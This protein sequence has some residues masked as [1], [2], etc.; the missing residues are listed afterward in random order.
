[1]GKR[2]ILIVL[3]SVGC[4]GAPDAAAYG[5]AGADTLGHLFEGIPG[6]RLPNLDSLG[7][8]GLM[9]REPSG[10]LRQG[11]S[12]FRL[13]EVSAGKDT[14][15]G[16][17]ELMGCLLEEPFY[18]C[19]SFPQGFVDTLAAACGTEFIGNKAASGTQILEE[20][21][22]EHLRTGFP[23]LYTSADSVLQIAAHEGTFGEGRLQDVCRTARRLLD[24]RGMRV[25]RVISRPFTGDETSGFR[26]TANRHDYSLTPGGTVLDDLVAKHVEVI[27]VGKISDIFAGK[28]ISVSHPTA[29]NAHG[30][31]LVG[32]LC[33]ERAD[34]EEFIFANLVDFDSLYGH[35][36]DPLGYARC[37]VEFDVWLGGFLQGLH[38]DELLM[39]TADHGN[40]PYHP[41]T[42]HTREQVPCL[43]V[44]GNGFDPGEMRVFADVGECVLR[45]FQK[46]SN[47]AKTRGYG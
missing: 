28:A 46:K 9:G 39:I 40:D 3:D 32:S 33:E 2:A 21:G 18:T 14:T 38:P 26:R 24:E 47:L 25:G 43:V 13:T 7:L 30:M 41:G 23:I 45:F 20:L 42:D 6:L 15:T 5:D 29:G 22:G 10:P 12:A 4:G 19:E 17:W 27:G 35:R 1:M 44:S 31:A 8:A 36:R 37:L 34:Q 11:A 16:H